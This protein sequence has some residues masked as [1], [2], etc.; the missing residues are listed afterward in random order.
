MLDRTIGYERI[1]IGKHFCVSFQRTLRIPDE[2]QQCPVLPG[3]GEF[4]TYRSS[5][6]ARA[7]AQLLVL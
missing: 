5:D 3:L 7:P 4:P 6:Y 1:E 2:G